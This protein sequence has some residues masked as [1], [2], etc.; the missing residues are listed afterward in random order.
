MS[1]N[2]FVQT[3]EAP[4]FDLLDEQLR[5]ALGDRVIGVSASGTDVTVHFADDATDEQIETARQI[6]E[7]HDPSERTSQQ[8]ETAERAI[9]LAELREENTVPLDLADYDEADNSL[10][11]LA[12]K[13]AW[14][15]Q[16][17]IALR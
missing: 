10:R 4:N 12:V 9:L 8:Q 16:E 15:E 5:S 2:M 14:L 13:I 7:Q 17:L 3:S 1:E 6:V 11:Q